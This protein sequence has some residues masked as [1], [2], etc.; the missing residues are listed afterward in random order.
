MTVAFFDR[1]FS[2]INW[3]FSSTFGLGFLRFFKA[4]NP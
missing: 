3:F 1:L 2:Q 4:L